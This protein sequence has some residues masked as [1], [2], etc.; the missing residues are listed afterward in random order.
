MAKNKK[1]KI[2]SK[3]VDGQI[4]TAIANNSFSKTLNQDIKNAT[5]KYEK[6]E[7][8]DPAAV[9]EKVSDLKERVGKV[10]EMVNV[11]LKSKGTLDKE[12]SDQTRDIDVA[13]AKLVNAAENNLRGT[14][15]PKKSADARSRGRKQKD[16]YATYDYDQALSTCASLKSKDPD[17]TCEPVELETTGKYVIDITMPGGKEHLQETFDA[18]EMP[19]H[20]CGFDYDSAAN[21]SNALKRR[22]VCTEVVPD[23]RAAEGVESYCVLLSKSSPPCA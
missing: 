18:N 9:I 14:C 11:F 15:S 16:A 3:N 4:A 6:C 17:I 10:D 1:C 19:K 7:K 12:D 13:G 5:E 21:I 8:E 23:W 22:G 2:A 20:W